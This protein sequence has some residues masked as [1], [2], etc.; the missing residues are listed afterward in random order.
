MSQ[1]ASSEMLTV[2]SDIDD[3]YE[4]TPPRRKQSVDSVLAAEPMT[5][6]QRLYL[7]DLRQQA[8]SYQQ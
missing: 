8:S 4:E 5:F 6:A 2:L 3:S 1:P 7:M